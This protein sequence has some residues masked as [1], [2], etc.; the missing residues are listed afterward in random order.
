MTKR[1]FLA[2]RR[3][4]WARFTELL[5]RFD[6]RRLRGRTAGEV[7]E[8]SRGLRELAADLAAVRAHGWGDR[9]DEYLNTL[10]G[11][12]HTA[13]YAA[14]ASPLG[15]AAGYLLHGFPRVFRRNGR[16]FLVAAVLFFGPFCVAWAA[17][18]LRP[19][20]A[21]RILPPEAQAMYDEMYAEGGGLDPDGPSEADSGEDDSG[22]AESAFDLG[23]YGGQRSLMAGFYV[24]NNVGI[25]LKCFAL[26][27]TF[28]LG[29]IYVLLSN[30]IQIGAV[31]GY[32]GVSGNGER[33]FSFAVTHGSFELTAIAV[34]G[35]AGLMLADA[36]L[37]PGR[38]SRL[39]SLIVRGR[40]AI[41][42]AAGAAVMLMIAAG[43][44]A[45]WSP[46][47]IAPSV[48]YAVGGSLWVAVFAWL[49]LAGRG[50]A[51]AE[52]TGVNQ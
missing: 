11:R 41:Q 37:H 40:E 3:P 23:A 14:P 6:R 24:Y 5:D 12:G 27:V 52:P 38:R 16:F 36:M 42:V 32:A 30:G 9:L 46:A 15:G 49:L 51:H 44:E 34:A 8:L 48:K 10:L 1:D 4:R 17:V 21:D 2:A 29:T 26:G 18:A 33:L 35:G 25:A 22:E 7:A 43:L 45:F 50:G 20:L 31:F 47:P 19:S 39:G 13:F 28:G